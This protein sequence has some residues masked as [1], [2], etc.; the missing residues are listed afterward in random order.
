VI[1][2]ALVTAASLFGASLAAKM[3]LTAA[4]GQAALWLAFFI[5]G[6]RIAAL[7]RGGK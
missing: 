5:Q 1:A 6:Q 2:V 3:W 4:L 7:E